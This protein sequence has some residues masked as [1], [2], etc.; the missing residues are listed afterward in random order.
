MKKVS[1]NITLK[2]LKKSHINQNYLNWFND[3]AIKKYITYFPKNLN[4]L[5]KD[6]NKNLREKTTLMLGIFN[7]SK[8]IGNLKIHN[9]N[10]KNFSASIGILI[11][12]KNSRG[13]GYG[14]Y[15]INLTKKILLKKKIYIIELGV[16]KSNKA[17]FNLYKACNFEIVKSAKDYYIMECKN[18]HNKM[19]LG[20][21]QFRSKYGVTNKDQ[22]IMNSNEIKKI[23]SYIDQKSQINEIDTATNYNLNSNDLKNMKNTIFVNNKIHT[24]DKISYSNLKKYFKKNEKFQN[25]TLFIHDGNNV[26]SKEGNELLLKI[27]KLKKAKIINKVGLSIHNVQF[28]KKILDKTSVDVIQLPY[29]FV[30]RRAEKFFKIMKKKKIEIQVR[31][32]FLQGSLLT[33]IK[34]NKKLSKLYEKFNKISNNN[35]IIKIKFI[36]SFVLRNKYIDKI[37][38][39][40]RNFKEFE[41]LNIIHNLECNLSKLEQLKTNDEE[42]IN[43]LKW[44]ELILEKK[45]EINYLNK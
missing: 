34:T 4:E 26:L 29:N 32:I 35:H 44:D 43:P 19:V 15:V 24:D 12:D 14:K 37:I 21:A 3:K 10:Y 23:I 31:S 9:I 42:V 22:N 2:P 25:N 7:G 39:G 18:F 28:L 16:H 20:T 11:G 45:K 38:F 27:K 5:K 33:K 1:K 17:A 41:Q 13:K 8:H 36:L 6:V 40:V 30:D